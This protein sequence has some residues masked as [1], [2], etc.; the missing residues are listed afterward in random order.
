MSDFPPTEQSI[1]IARRVVALVGVQP[2]DEGPDAL[3]G[4]GMTFDNGVDAQ[5]CVGVRNHYDTVTVIHGRGTWTGL[6]DEAAERVRR[7]LHG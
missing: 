1:E 3:G 7:I 4:I 2:I 5:V 6:P